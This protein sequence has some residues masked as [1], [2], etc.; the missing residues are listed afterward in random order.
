MDERIY[1]IMAKQLS[2]E[3]DEKEQLE[4]EEWLSSDLSHKAEYEEMRQ[5]WMESDDVLKDPIVDTGA[6][7]NKIMAATIEKPQS[8]V[9]PQPK[10]I[11]LPGWTKY[12]AGIAAILLIAVLV[13]KPLSRKGMITAMAED[14]NKEVVLPDNSHVTLRAGSSLKYPA[15]FA[16][17]ERH[18]ILEGEAF[19]KVTRDEARPFTID[20]ASAEVK[21]LGTSFNVNCSD[22][23]TTVVVATGKVQMTALKSTAQSVVLTPGEQGILQ[24]NNLTESSVNDNNYLYWMTG[25]L[26]FENKTLQYIAGELA[27]IGKTTI[28]FAQDMPEA[29]KNQMVTISFDHQPLE[30]ML[31]ELCMVAKCKWAKEN[32][33]YIISSGDK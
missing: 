14:V 23:L 13:W 21:V 31:A 27:K 18:V 29:V 22:S 12:A 19:F 30:E 2:G 6:A 33:M 1:I 26:S 15:A 10:I 4:L 5:L 25:V 9:S 7:W 24:N 11:G 32:N 3:A 28:G 16:K 17:N 20:A 8:R